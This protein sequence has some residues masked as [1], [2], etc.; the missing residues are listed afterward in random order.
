M[1]RSLTDQHYLISGRDV[2]ADIRILDLVS[3]YQ[4]VAQVK[5]RFT[6]DLIPLV[7]PSRKPVPRKGEVSGELEV[8]ITKYTR[9]PEG[10]REKMTLTSSDHRKIKSYIAQQISLMRLGIKPGKTRFE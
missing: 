5:Y 2:Y 3:S 1:E 7:H 9:G 6:A 8:T 4:A 10:L